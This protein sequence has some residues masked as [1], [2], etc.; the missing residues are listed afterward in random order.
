MVLLPWG[1][2]S[3]QMSRS[4]GVVIPAYEPVVDSLVDYLHA[5]HDHLDPATVRVELDAPDA[6]TVT[7]LED[8]PCTVHAVDR[9][10]GKGA[11]ITCGFEALDT[12][13]LAFADAD[14]ATPAES[15][16]DVVQPVVDGS[17]KLSVGS[18]RHPDANVLSHQTVARRYLGDGFAFLART[19][20]SVP[21]YD[22]QCGA[23][24]IDAEAWASVRDHLYEPG[25]AWDIELVAMAGALGY[26]PV[27]VAVTWEDQPESTVSP[28]GTTLEL[29]VSLLKSRHRMKRLQ[30]SS[31]HRF[32]ASRRS[33]SLSLVDRLGAETDE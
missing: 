17:A 26:E 27:E 33:T 3:E 18:R 2:R 8:E 25:F 23:K 32:V 24:A 13:V 19:L 15:I 30:G 5:L 31:L 7:A 12:D 4:V 20:L 29:G 16:V 14:G 21:L 28:V 10:R 11:A 22:F 1:T 6:S 9:R